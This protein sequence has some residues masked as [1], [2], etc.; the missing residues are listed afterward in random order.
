MSEEI[1]RIWNKDESVEQ[2]TFQR[3][4]GE[5]PEMECTKQLVSLI[6]DEYQSGLKILD[7]GCASG[8][9]YNGIKRIDEGIQL[10]LR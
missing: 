7:V 10:G 5:L 9:Y 2:R 8:H 4:T 3:T 6:S 1:W